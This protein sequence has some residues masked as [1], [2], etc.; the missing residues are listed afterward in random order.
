MP[1][2]TDLSLARIGQ[3]SIP[4]QDLDRAA[5]FYREQL[6]LKHLFT[7]SKLAFFD[8]G[9]IRLMLSVPES[10]EFDHPSSVL[11]FSVDDIQKVFGTLSERSVRFEGPP[12]LIAKMESYDLW[13][14]FFRDS[15]NNLLSLMCNVTKSQ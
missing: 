1:D 10:P 6:G 7:V 13:M 15:E 4:V 14:A 12:H 2:A 9:G 3:I 5:A 8:C 11:Y